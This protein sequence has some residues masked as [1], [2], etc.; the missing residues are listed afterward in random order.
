MGNIK[1]CMQVR[2]WIHNKGGH[3]V[4]VTFYFSHTH[5]MDLKQVTPLRAA[6]V[7]VKILSWISPEKWNTFNKWKKK[8]CYIDTRWHCSPDCPTRKFRFSPERVWGDR[9]KAKPKLTLWPS[10][11]QLWWTLSFSFPGPQDPWVPH[12]WPLPQR[13]VPG[14]LIPK[15]AIKSG[16]LLLGP[17][18]DSL[19]P[20]THHM[21]T[22]G[23]QETNEVPSVSG[24]GNQVHSS[25]RKLDS[26]FNLL[27][28]S[29]V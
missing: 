4:S 11:W 20:R 18:W 26:L 27:I 24:L 17:S 22:M 2:H 15:A 16:S 14:T 10:C 29:T 23:P 25:V 3:T 12:Q 21:P 28:T 8:L 6:Q 5:K 9:K 7:D 13:N 1:P 19:Q